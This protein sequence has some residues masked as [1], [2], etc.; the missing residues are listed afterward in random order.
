MA[1]IST[2]LLAFVRPGVTIRY[3]RPLSGG[4]IFPFAVNGGEAEA[5]AILDW[6]EIMKLAVSLGGTE[7]LISHPATKMHSGVAKELCE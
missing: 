3:C 5:I 4:S 1:A 7:T 6:L 2:L